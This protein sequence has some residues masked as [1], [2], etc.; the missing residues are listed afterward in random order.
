MPRNLASA[1]YALLA[2]LFLVSPAAAGANGS[3]PPNRPVVSGPSEVHRLEGYWITWTNVLSPRGSGQ[4][5]TFLI[6]RSEDPTFQSGVERLQPTTRTTAT[7]G[8]PGGAPRTIYHRV[9]VQSFCAGTSPIRVESTVF[10]V[11][12]TDQCRVPIALA[13]PVASD[14]R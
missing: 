6:E 1:R 8:P 7:W 12:V 3:C 13:P 10:A 5:D 4:P 11:R 2:G 9:A 14:P